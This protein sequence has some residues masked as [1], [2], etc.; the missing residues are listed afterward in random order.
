MTS[1]TPDQPRAF[2]EPETRIYLRCPRCKYE[3]EAAAVLAGV[4]WGR[5]VTPGAIAGICYCPRCHAD[6][7]MEPATPAP[8]TKAR[9]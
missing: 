9:R 5:G 4:W 1:T 3:W 6:P 2:A 7:P 8:L